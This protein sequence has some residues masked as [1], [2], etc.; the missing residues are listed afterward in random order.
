M[1]FMLQPIIWKIVIGILF[2]VIIVS[3]IQYNSNVR[4]HNLGEA[5]GI[6][7]FAFGMMICM[8]IAF[9]I[10]DECYIYLYY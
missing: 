3:L 7:F 2:I 8:I 10:L 5:A 9:Y 4:D 1:G 6:L